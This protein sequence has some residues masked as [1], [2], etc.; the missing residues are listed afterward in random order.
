M[1][2]N[3][4][5]KNITQTSQVSNNTDGII[6]LAK[7]A[8][9]TSFSSL[10]SVKKALNT[11]KVG[12]TGTLDS[13]AQGLLIVCTGHLTK[14]A[15]KITEFDKTYQAVIKFG[16][17]TDTYEYTGKITKTTPLPNKTD[18]E[19]AVHKFTGEIMQTPPFFS[20][21]HINGERASSLAR[22]GQKVEIPAR[23]VTIFSSKILDTVCNSQNQVECALVE[24]SVSKGTYIRSLAVDIARECNSSAHLA[25]LYRTK[26][27]NFL[28]QDAAGFE[29][30]QN[31]SIQTA[32]ETMIEQK[33]ILKKQEEQRLLNPQKNQKQRFIPSAQELQLQQ[34]IIHKKLSFTPKIASQCGLIPLYFANRE[35]ENSFFNGKTLTYSFFQNPTELESLPANKQAAVFTQ[36]NIFAGIIEKNDKG[37]LEYCFVINN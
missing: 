37:K 14:L 33:E 8:G 20:A 30:V 23:K 7:Q 16:E 21:I 28:I 36:Q 9:L 18:F 2:Q 3:H 1:N 15:G 10:N 31:F 27:G 34:E 25:G 32:V 4:P 5:T 35:S 26:V 11:K 22:N 17:E 24:F 12:H 6:L 29:N 13:F 19:K